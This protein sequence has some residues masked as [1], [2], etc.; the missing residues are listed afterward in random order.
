MS[1]LFTNVD[2]AL[3]LCETF[4]VVDPYIPSGPLNLASPRVR[5]CCWNASGQCAAR[6]EK[7]LD[8]GHEG[9][10]Q[11][12]CPRWS[13]VEDKGTCGSDHH[14]FADTSWR[15]S[16]LFKLSEGVHHG[17][18]RSHC[19]SGIYIQPLSLRGIT[20]CTFMHI[21]TMPR[22]TI[23]I[24][25]TDFA[26]SKVDVVHLGHGCRPSTEIVRKNHS[27]TWDPLLHAMISTAINGSST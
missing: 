11:S 10:D 25:S 16:L 20:W 1:F 6:V 21:P 14:A 22:C 8:E 26:K 12:S 19:S 9:Y 18:Q 5:P 15:S 24:S 4:L 17:S 3:V 13:W 23:S 27:N 2:C 7:L